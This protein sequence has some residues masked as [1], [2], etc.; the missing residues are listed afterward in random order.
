[1]QTKQPTGCFVYNV[2]MND[3][4]SA[5]KV[6]SRWYTRFADTAFEDYE[7]LRGDKDVREAEKSKFLA[8]EVDNPTLDYPKLETFNLDER[9]A[10]LLSLK[11]DV[12]EQEQNEA[13][14]QIYHA[15]INEALATLHMLRAAKSGDDE[16]FSH[17]AESVYGT[18]D[19]GDVGYVI[20]HVQGLIAQH[21]DS[22]D[23]ERQ[24][25][26]Q[27]LA[28]IF[29]DLVADPGAG[30]DTSVLP[31]GQDISGKVESLAEVVDAFEAALQEVG[32]TD[33]NVVVDSE[34][35]ITDFAVSQEHK[36]V[37]VPSEENVFARELTKKKLAGLIAHEIKTHVARRSNGERSKL[38]LLGLG[39]AGYLKAEEGIATYAEQ[40]VTGAV[41]F[42]GMERFFSIALAKGLTGKALDFRG[43]YEIMKDYNLIAPSRD[44]EAVTKEWADTTAY[45]D[46]VRIFRGTT[47]TT[48]GAVYPKD[49]SY[50]SN[51]AI[52][53][54]VSAHPDAVAT[55]TLGKFDPRNSEHVAL[56]TQLGILGG[57]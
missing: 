27:R 37:N 29:G 19:P 5:E 23:V 31:V 26:A 39:L 41:E 18:P 21:L 53:T 17:C 3:I 11:E 42:D 15:K 25:A 55:F 44:A 43:T 36:I 13:V 10:A 38:Q 40:Q 52:W 49:M 14:K 47:C 22:E 2:G 33:W 30:V 1:M 32:A 34:V 50:F 28:H 24:Q 16:Q 6:D 8:G 48:S 35:G 51:R 7:K 57:N 54:L 9:E 4:Q 45:D 12:L 46:C 20:K 56:L